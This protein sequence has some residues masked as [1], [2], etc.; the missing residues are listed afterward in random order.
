MLPAS[1]GNL[2]GGCNPA[3]SS[4]YDLISSGILLE[5]DFFKIHFIGWSPNVHWASTIT[6]LMLF[7]WGQTFQ[8][9]AFFKYCVNQSSKYIKLKLKNATQGAQ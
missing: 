8:G 5:H 2:S 9:N 6:F 4:S 7:F 1:G 3:G